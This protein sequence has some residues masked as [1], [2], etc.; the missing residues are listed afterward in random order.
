MKGEV[1]CCR[2]GKGRGKINEAV[3]AYKIP[4]L[5][6]HA[7]SERDSRDGLSDCW[8]VCGSFCAAMSSLVENRAGGTLLLLLLGAHAQAK[9]SQAKPDQARSRPG[10]FWSGR[11]A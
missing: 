1:G 10:L 2:E 7:H 6:T 9:S 3:A 4:Q 5:D 8:L 11:N